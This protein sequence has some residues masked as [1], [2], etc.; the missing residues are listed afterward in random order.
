MEAAQPPLDDD[1]HHHQLA[2][3][4][5]LMTTWNGRMRTKLLQGL[6]SGAFSAISSQYWSF[7]CFPF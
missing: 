6:C 4:R 5:W 7:S 3:R 2:V 1:H